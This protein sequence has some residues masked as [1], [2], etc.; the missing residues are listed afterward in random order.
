M[1][2]VWIRRPRRA[3]PAH[4]TLFCLPFAGGGAGVFRE[5]AGLLPKGVEVLP[6]HLPGRE[7]RFNEAAIDD[8]DALVEQLL[9]GLLPHVDGPFALFGHSMGGLIAFELAD[10]L[11][12]RG[13]APAWFFPSGVQAPHLPRQVEARHPLPDDEFLASVQRLNGIPRELLA[14]PEV[15]QLMLPTLR[16]DFRLV[17]TYR[18]RPRPPLA[19]P[20]VAF[21]G[22]DD[23]EVPPTKLEAWREQA[24]G[25]FEAHLIG[26][27]HFFINTSRAELLRLIGER[28]TGGAA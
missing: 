4:V 9:E 28:L 14:N 6:V 22:Q 16:R 2:A 23:P 1:A 18:Y 10:R 17:E 20:V 5:W 27:D 3:G 25:P 13:L 15:V 26:G 21:G 7:A 24:A 8:V 12:R 19:C 11:R